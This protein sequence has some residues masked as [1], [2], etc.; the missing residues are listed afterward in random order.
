MIKPAQSRLTSRS[1]KTALTFALLMGTMG[2][3]GANSQTKEQYYQ[4]GVSAYQAQNFTQAF[5]FFKTSCDAGYAYGCA[6]LG[7]MY[8]GGQ[9]VEKDRSTARIYHDKA[10]AA[11]M[12]SACFNLGV[13]QRDAE[14]GPA[15]PV[16]ARVSFSK[17]CAIGQNYFCFDY[18]NM[19][20]FGDGGPVDM[21]GARSSFT[22]SCADDHNTSCFNLGMMQAKGDGGPKE[23]E[24]SAAN[25]AKACTLGFERAPSPSTDQR[26]QVREAEARTRLISAIG[27]IAASEHHART[28]TR[29]TR[30]R[31]SAP[32]R[33][34]GLR[35]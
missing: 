14:G 30:S 11:D 6:Y 24:A 1:L 29:R 34:R 35:P 8:Q 32:H 7:A 12:A 22:V 25:F 3:L 13:L 33:S 21:T 17:A 26:R 16:K 28:P 10:C 19:Q 27:R 9:G 18:G 15:D 4:A 20:V 23:A 5:T 31:D 2:Q